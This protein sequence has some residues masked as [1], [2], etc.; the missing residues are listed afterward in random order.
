MRRRTGIWSI[1][2]F[3]VV[4]LFSTGAYSQ[5]T[6]GIR[7]RVSD[8]AT[9]GA[10]A[11]VVVVAR[12]PAL[13]GE[14]IAVTER[15]GAF[16]ISFLPPGRYNLHFEADGY[17]V[18]QM[19]N[20]EVQLG[21]TTPVALDLVPV[22]V[23]AERITVT[24]TAPTIDRGSTETGSN[25]NQE[26]IRNT[27]QGRRYTDVLRETPGTSTDDY[28]STVFG[29][30]GV[31][32]TYV[33]EGLNT[34]DTGFGRVGLNLNTDFFEELE[35]KTGGYMPEFGRSTGGIFNLVLRNGGNEYH[36]D[37]FVNVSPGF[38]RAREVAIYRVGESIG[39]EDDRTLDLDFGFDIGGPII[40]DRLWF[41]AGFTPQIV[42]TDVSRIIQTQHD[43]AGDRIDSDPDNGICADGSGLGSVATCADAD[44][45][46]LGD[47]A[48][49]DQESLTSPD[50]EADLDENGN[51]AVRELSRRHLSRKRVYWQFAG[52]LTLALNPDNRVSL[53]YFGNPNTRDGVYRAIDDSRTTNGLSGDEA[54]YNGHSA[55][56]SHNLVLNY[57]SQLFDR[58]FQVEAFAGYHTQRDSNSNESGDTPAHDSVYMRPLA[59]FEPGVCPELT[60][61]PFI[62]CPVGDYS[63]GDA[64]WWNEQL[65][66][67]TAGLRLTNLF[68]G[69]RVRYGFE[70][71][72]KQYNTEEG[73]AGG[74][75]V[76]DRDPAI[77]DVRAHR[78]RQFATDDPNN[79]DLPYIYDQN[80]NPA[81]EANISTL[82]LTAYLQDSWEIS[83]HFTINGG[84]RWDYESLSDVNG[85]AQMDIP[86]EI[87]PRL[88]ISYDPTGVGRGRF[89]ASWGWYYE[90]I[91]LD[92]AVREFSQQGDAYQY[93][94][95]TGKPQCFHRDP[96]TGAIPLDEEGYD[97]YTPV[98]PAVE[99]DCI[100]WPVVLAGE[101]AGVNNNLQGQYTEEFTVGAE[102][103]V[104]PDWVLGVTGVVRRL[105]RVVEDISP[106]GGW[107]YLVANPGENDC[108]VPAAYRESFADYCSTDRNGNGTFE[109]DE[110]DPDIRQFDK[111]RRIYMGLILAVRKR[112]SNHSQLLAS[113]TLSRNEGDYSGLYDYDYQQLDPN[114]TAQY[115]LPSLMPNRYGLLSNDH[116]H[117]IKFSG[118]Y[119]LG[120]LTRTLDGLTVGLGYH[121][122]SGVPYSYLGAHEIYDR[123]AAFIFPRGS[124]GR[125]PFTHQFDAYVGYD[126][127]ITSGIK[128]NLNATVFNLLNSQEA[129]LVDSEY[130]TSVVL[131]QAPGTKLEDV[132]DIDGNP[133]VPN[134]TFGEPR[135][136]QAPLFVR[137][138]ARLSF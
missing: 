49:A 15:N 46:G 121:G 12:S 137:L 81:F 41:F 126:I 34:T 136:R 66:R 124:A 111:P 18:G 63:T 64:M 128:L 53:A 67:E 25:L 93:L 134:P 123:G 74:Y 29:S 55:G 110:Y 1:C 22:A 43:E 11:G 129:T 116:T 76:T 71:E 20:V 86:D 9:S 104:V 127:P 91:P 4:L 85:E 95:D 60:S 135:S 94:D 14:Q 125:T 79:P 69:H 26:F 38:L 56:G 42:L 112:L 50:G 35:V 45:D 65:N 75:H 117:S 132:R 23:E 54:Y 21:Q 44:G 130:T 62:D 98:D 96:E 90:S 17:R 40:K 87:A 92:I 131:P 101:N 89:F 28:G 32:N 52:K 84:V 19:Q 36:G 57:T 97:V 47:L 61:T 70:A 37:V 103:E 122:E 78:T 3:A 7:G 30:T 27:P 83:R 108:D 107:T 115:D 24:A 31:E 113:Y 51:P 80:G 73:Y 2:S 48:A 106:D 100:L 58:H 72:S 13:Q 6:G 120:G 8:A 138:G 5:T 39:R 16:V 68:S 99:P 114:L 119:E 33:I 82:N 133:V 77:Y 10:I 88:G 105:G 102:Y 118:S 59:D 109:P